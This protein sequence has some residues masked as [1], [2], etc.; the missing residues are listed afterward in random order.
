MN[1]K[2]KKIICIIVAVFLLGIVLTV[3]YINFVMKDCLI[4]KVF[5]RGDFEYSISL[6]YRYSVIL[7][8]TGNDENVDVPNTFLFLPVVKVRESAFEGNETLKEVNLPKNLKN[9]GENAFRDCTSLQQVHFAGTL[10]YIYPYAFYN[11]SS[12]ETLEI[13]YKE[14]ETTILE[15]AFENCINLTEVNFNDT[16]VYIEEHAFYNCE[17]LESVI[18][19]EKIRAAPDSFDNTAILN[20]WNNGDYFILGHWLVKYL[21][22]DTDIIIPDGVTG[23]STIVFE[24]MQIKT[25]KMPSGIN[26]FAFYFTYNNENNSEKVIIYYPKLES[27]YMPT[28]GNILTAREH[29]ILSSPEGSAVIEYAKEN[30]IEYIIEE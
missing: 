29:V 6:K 27:F 20:N 18:G 25:I 13:P 2:L 4:D 22:D 15:S 17:K 9:I 1:K 26:Y 19:V 21:G 14:K 24:G 12:L 5:V 16:E 3:L 8:Y 30:D 23:M 28:W 10:G 7:K 11:C